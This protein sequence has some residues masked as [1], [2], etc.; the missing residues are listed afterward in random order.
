MV[1]MEQ[2]LLNMHEYQAKLETLTTRLK[3][4][5]EKDLEILSAVVQLK[6][7][8]FFQETHSTNS[9]PEEDETLAINF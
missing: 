7:I 1:N 2:E 3:N 5:L 6:E 4:E 9:S 8:T